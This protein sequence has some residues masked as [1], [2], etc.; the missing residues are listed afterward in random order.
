MSLTRLFAW[1]REENIIS[2]TDRCKA[3]LLRRHHKTRHLLACKCFAVS[4]RAW[5]NSRESSAVRLR[6]N[7][8]LTLIA[9][10]P[11]QLL[12]NFA[13][14]RPFYEVGSCNDLKLMKISELRLHRQCKSVWQSKGWDGRVDE[15]NWPSTCWLLPGGKLYSNF[16]RLWQTSSNSNQTFWRQLCR[17]FSFLISF[18]VAVFIECNRITFN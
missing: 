15:W 3:F 9:F 16:K 4:C 2:R 7:L 18:F 13:C 11:L 8:V 14:C 6:N 1:R 5:N 12:F 17:F 10:F